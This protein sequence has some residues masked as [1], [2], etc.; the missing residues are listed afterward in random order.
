M[1]Q[2][3]LSLHERDRR[4]SLTLELMKEKG[5]DCLIVTPGNAFYSP[6]YY[7]AWLTDDNATGTVIFPLKGEPTYIV[8]SPMHCTIRMLE[9]RKRGIEP[10]ME[11]YRVFRRAMEGVVL[12]LREKSLD[13]SIIG[14][15]GLRQQGPGTI[16]GIAYGDWSHVIEQLPKA[17]FVDIA[18]PFGRLR[19]VKSSEDIV[20]ARYA[21]YVGDLACEAMVKA[22]KPGVSE[23]E[24]Y[25]TIMSTIFKHAANALH[26][27]IHTGINNLSWGM[28]MWTGRAQIPDVVGKGDIIQAEIF[29]IYG[30]MESQQQMSVATKPVAP[31]TQELADIARKSYEVAINMMRP[32]ITFGE[33]CDAMEK[34][35]REPGCGYMTPLAHTMNPII[36]AS[37]AVRGI[38]QIPELKNYP[39]FQESHQM[40]PAAREYVLEPGVLFELEP[41]AFRSTPQGTQKV[42]IGGTVIITKDGVEELN[43]MATRMV[44]SD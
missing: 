38:D 23:S 18:E 27:I 21:A 1:E 20:L 44:V 22:V 17:T 32:G 25:A 33:V 7:D 36:Y 12:I 39:G 34:V 15:V 6:D 24:I 30:G 35:I 8:W 3:T 10:W 37:A 19:L 14:V 2:P 28:P 29:P 43:K 13:S 9:N 5:L 31:L 40:R 4:W 26:V 11:D 41:N 16:G 42:N